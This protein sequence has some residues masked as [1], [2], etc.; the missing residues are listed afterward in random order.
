MKAHQLIDTCQHDGHVNT[1]IAHRAVELA[2]R[3]ATS[4]QPLTYDTDRPVQVLAPDAILVLDA[5]LCIVLA[6]PGHRV[7][8]TDVAS[9]QDGL[10][11]AKTFQQIYL[12]DAEQARQEAA[13]DRGRQRFEAARILRRADPAFR[14]LTSWARDDAVSNLLADYGAADSQVSLAEYAAG[15][16][17]KYSH[18]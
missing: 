17:R 1:N 3:Q 7:T 6:V 5:S 13:L 12:D 10:G 18:G 15:W 11:N 4:T 2:V 8:V 16:V 9:W 14:G